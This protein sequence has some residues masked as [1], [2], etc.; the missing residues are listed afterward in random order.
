MEWSA[1]VEGAEVGA[2]LEG[3]GSDRQRG[4]GAGNVAEGTQ[5]RPQALVYFRLAG[6][7]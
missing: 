1:G 4:T 6:E 5:D 3:G 7:M 2:E